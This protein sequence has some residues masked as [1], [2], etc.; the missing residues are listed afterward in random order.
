MDAFGA[1]GVV[2]QSNPDFSDVPDSIYDDQ[3]GQVPG[4]EVA[5]TFDQPIVC[6]PSLEAIACSPSLEMEA[7]GLEF[8]AEASEDTDDNDDEVIQIDDDQSQERGQV[9]FGSF[10]GSRER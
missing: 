9:F 3:L 1:S 8:E 5:G 2:E 7:N 10:G 4:E 6:S